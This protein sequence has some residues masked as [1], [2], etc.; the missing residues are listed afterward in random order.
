MVVRLPATVVL[1]DSALHVP[2][3]FLG[4]FPP[5]LWR[6][7][8]PARSLENA[9]VSGAQLPSGA[10]RDDALQRML[11]AGLVHPGR[12][13][14]ERSGAEGLVAVVVPVH[15]DQ[16]GLDATLNA[17][18]AFENANLQ[19]SECVIVDDGSIEPIQIQVDVTFPIR[20]L[21]NEHVRGPAA[22]RNAGW[23][24]TS[25]ALVLFVDAN[26]SCEPTVIARLSDVVALQGI[27]IVS[28]RV[29]Q[30]PGRG[31]FGDAIA[32]TSSL[33]L[34]P[35]PAVVRR[36]GRVSY[37]PG[38]CLLIKRSLL[39]RLRGFDETLHTGEDVDFIWRADALGFATRYEPSVS[40]THGERSAVSALRRRFA[41][42]TSTAQLAA[43][44]RGAMAPFRF[45]PSTVLACGLALSGKRMA[46]CTLAAARLAA[47][48]VTLRRI[49]ATRQFATRLAV[50]INSTEVLGI[51]NGIC[52]PEFPIA[53]LCLA[54]RRTRRVTALAIAVSLLSRQR[55][56]HGVPKMKTLL[57]Q[58]ADDSAYSAGV[59]GAALRSRQLGPLLP[60]RSN[61]R[62]NIMRKATA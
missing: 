3:Q 22:A 57:W 50:Q 29:C 33:D 39:E 49:D 1:D 37:V 35:S 26:V 53:L 23:I 13:E 20:V 60:K 62:P 41:Y 15:E 61:F 10:S 34:G 14:R 6:I 31:S 43:Q 2:G 9:V 38:C 24:A 18:N 25:A 54:G 48:T 5:R 7:R 40:A 30:A 51:A 56:G 12:F 17:L 19:I 8:P 59:W 42:G 11:A 52:R 28:P 55:R 36:D 45:R 46:A 21:R 27:G 47:D 58:L 32:N 44:H 4:G 16:A